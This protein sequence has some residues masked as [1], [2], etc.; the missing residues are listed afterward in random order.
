MPA[1]EVTVVHALPGRLRLKVPR[2]KGDAAFA[3]RVEE[4]LRVVPALLEVTAV[5]LTGSVVVHYDPQAITSPA[6]LL[7]LSEAVTELF[8]GLNLEELPRLLTPEENTATAP[9][10]S[11]AAGL[12]GFFSQLNSQVS[13]ATGGLIDLK[14]LLPLSLFGLGVRALL[15]DSKL[16][17][18]WYDYFWFGFSIFVMLNRGLWEGPAAAPEA[19]GPPRESGEIPLGEE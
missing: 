7:A 19:G 13:A 14:M 2:V 9:T 1:Q 6:A 17:P 10:S 11:L 18:S 8:P 16:K 3:R 4:R 15:T 5:P 12:V